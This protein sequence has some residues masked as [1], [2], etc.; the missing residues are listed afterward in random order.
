MKE[1]HVLVEIHKIRERHFD[2]TKGMSSVEFL[3][4][5]KNE[6]APIKKTIQDKK[7]LVAKSHHA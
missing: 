3:K 6:V 2:E 1:S 4:S 5:L 7:K